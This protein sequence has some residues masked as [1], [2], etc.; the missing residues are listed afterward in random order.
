MQ[1]EAAPIYVVGNTFVLCL[2]KLYIYLGTHL[3]P[4]SLR[5][6]CKRSL[7][8]LWVRFVHTP[9]CFTPPGL[10]TCG[11]EAGYSW[12]SAGG[13]SLRGAR[14]QG[15]WSR[16]GGAN[17]RF[18]LAVRYIAG[19]RREGAYIAQ[20]PTLTKLAA[21][22]FGGCSG[23]KKLSTDLFGVHICYLHLGLRGGTSPPQPGK[24]TPGSPP[25]C[26]AF[27]TSKFV[28]L[29]VSQIASLDPLFVLPP[30]TPI[31]AASGGRPM[32]FSGV[33]RNF[34]RSCWTTCALAQWLLWSG[35]GQTS[36]P[37]G[38]R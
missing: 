22:I 35:K 29:C 38:V 13:A 25:S 2:F 26:Y 6:G 5:K 24:D 10:E 11:S 14:W 20:Q 36:S 1:L 15:A 9:L 21:V 30:R 23:A 31:H 7:N 32:F 17:R 34:S 8:P 16:D 27:S 12:P 28:P 18:R 33:S 37:A 4:S 3:L 19:R